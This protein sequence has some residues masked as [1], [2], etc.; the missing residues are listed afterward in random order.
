[1]W[2]FTN[3]VNYWFALMFVGFPQ[4][5][6]RAPPPTNPM[7]KRF[8]CG[9]LD[10]PWEKNLRGRMFMPKNT[11]FF[12]DDFHW[13]I[14]L[15]N[16]WLVWLCCFSSRYFGMLCWNW[17]SRCLL[18]EDNIKRRNWF[19]FAKQL[20]TAGCEVMYHGNC[21]SEGVDLESGCIL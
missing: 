4:S 16:I 15:C 6:P 1:M 14:F 17:F 19:S 3:W 12:L 2:S 5:S 13:V 21:R 7:K 11:G 10:F 20:G 18:L 9:G 8:R